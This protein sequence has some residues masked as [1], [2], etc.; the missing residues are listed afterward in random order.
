MHEEAV[1]RLAEVHERLANKVADLQQAHLQ[2]EENAAHTMAAIFQP[3][4]LTNI[5][6]TESSPD[7]A[8]RTTITTLD[9]RLEAFSENIAA[10]ETELAKSWREFDEV[11]AKLV[12]LGRDV[13][14]DDMVVGAKAEVEEIARVQ[15]PHDGRKSFKYTI[16]M[17][18]QETSTKAEGL[19]EDVKNLEH[20]FFKKMLKLE[21]V[22]CPAIHD[23]H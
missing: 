5:S 14:G 4:S 2:D 9:K 10:C 17:W 20:D 16:E 11:Q 19:R 8:R 3:L 15:K 6:I 21:K 1:H 23:Q 22:G 13:F 12:L 7:V 18:D